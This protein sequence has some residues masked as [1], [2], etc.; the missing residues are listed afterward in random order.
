MRTRFGGRGK[1]RAER[2]RAVAKVKFLRNRCQIFE[3]M[4][5]KLSMRSESLI[6]ALLTEV[7]CRHGNGKRHIGYHLHLQQG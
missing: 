4:L 1:C 2:K 5:K 7:E 6:G 3:I